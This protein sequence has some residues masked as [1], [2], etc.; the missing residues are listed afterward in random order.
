MHWLSRRQPPKTWCAIEQEPDERTP[1]ACVARVRVALAA[2][3]H[4]AIARCYALIR[5][6]SRIANCLNARAWPYFYTDR[7]HQA[8]D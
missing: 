8:H 1:T 4:S 2:T 5:P 3:C 7:M 6:P